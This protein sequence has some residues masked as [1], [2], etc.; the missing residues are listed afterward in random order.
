MKI[1]WY[2]MMGIHAVPVFAGD[3]G[4]K[5]LV[6]MYHKLATLLPFTSGTKITNQEPTRPGNTGP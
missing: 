6:M 4:D 1:E 2:G 5:Q 3:K